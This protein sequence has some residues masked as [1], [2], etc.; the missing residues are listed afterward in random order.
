MCGI[1]GFIDTSQRVP[2]HTLDC[3]VRQMAERL[4]HRGPDDGGS[5]TDPE[6]GI[7]LGHRRLSI[8]DLSPLG[9]QPM[10]S[11]SAR[12]VLI[13]NGEIYNFRDLQVELEKS[14]QHFRGRSDTE[15]L[16]GAVDEWGFVSTLR[17]LNGMF[18]IALW[19]RLE[20]LLY[21]ARD[22]F[23]EKP[24]YYGWAG[25]V[26][27]FASELKALRAHPAFKPDI[28]RDAL[29]LYLR[30]DYVPTPH[31]IYRGIK[32]LAPASYV[33][34]GP[35][36]SI[37]PEP[38]QYWSAKEAVETGLTTPIRSSDEAVEQLDSLLLDA[39]KRRMV[40]DVPLG[41]F[42]SGGI[43][44]STVVALMQAQ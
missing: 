11:A 26:F 15:V 18:A 2:Q 9:R 24:L 1:V 10:V 33:V 28:D 42:L 36:P 7:A 29:A 40:A 20:R 13:F 3:T 19:D 22:R 5:W 8:L 21:M 14:G 38:Q 43:D 23:G 17:R 44:S 4:R 27:M 31:T 25:R 16:L 30:H 12:S 32:K 6:A 34:V 41:A 35:L 39:V 37:L